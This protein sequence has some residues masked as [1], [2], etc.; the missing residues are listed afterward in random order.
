VSARAIIYAFLFVG[1]ASSIA[2]G[3]ETELPENRSERIRVAFNTLNT[4]RLD[5]V[6]AFYAQNIRFEDPIV[7]LEDVDSLKEHYARLYRSV[8]SITFEF[9]DEYIADD[10]H[11]VEWEMTLQ[12]KRLNRGK[13]YTIPGSSI[14][15]FNGEN[16]V[17]YQRDYF[18]LGDMV[19]ERVPVVR[20]LTRF[21]KKR[22]T[23]KVPQGD[24]VE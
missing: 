23:P 14:I 1:S 2:T 7:T 18:D 11:I 4:D 10:T 8:K 16:K 13:P 20:F 21:V 3:Q 19:Y 17:T 22:L 6:V 15:T 9:T 24:S 12:A 5:I